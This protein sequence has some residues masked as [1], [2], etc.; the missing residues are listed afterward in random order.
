MDGR[1]ACSEAIN[2]PDFICFVFVSQVKSRETVD[3]QGDGGTFSRNKE[4]T[5]RDF[6]GHDMCNGCLGRPYK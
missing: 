1:E 6:L 2:H 3:R 4:G 5:N